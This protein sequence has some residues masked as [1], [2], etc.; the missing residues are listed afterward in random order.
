MSTGTAEEELLS[1]Q[2]AYYGL[3]AGEYDDDLYQDPRTADRLELLLTRLAP[4][5][6]ILELAC[7]TGVWTE[8]SAPTALGSA[9][10]LT[11]TTPIEPGKQ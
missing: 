1:A 6:R 2:L 11:D 4:A 9:G 3:R 8:L 10:R 7:G 5:G